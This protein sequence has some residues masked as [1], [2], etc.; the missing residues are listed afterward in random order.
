M[1]RM[2]TITLH[3]IPHNKHRYETV[4]DWQ[5]KPGAID[6]AVSRM[7]NADYEFCVALH[8][9]VEAWLCLRRGVDDRD[10]TEFDERFEADRKA[11]AH[12]ETEEPGDSPLAPYRDEHFTATTIE[13]M[14]AAELG[15]D[16]AKYDAKINSL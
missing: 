3:A 8:E 4:G 12:S 11:G 1:T 13:R 9:L 5:I 2:P 10:V 15:V 6:I 7:D 14:V 16:W